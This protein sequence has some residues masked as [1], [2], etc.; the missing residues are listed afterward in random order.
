MPEGVQGRSLLP[1]LTGR[2]YPKSEFESI[3]AE[4]GFGGLPRTDAGEDSFTWNQAFIKASD[5]SEGAKDANR[6]P[7]TFDELNSITQSGHVKMVRK[8]DWKLIYNFLGKTELYNLERDPAELN[9]LGEDEA[10]RSEREELE[11]ELI[12]WLVRLQ[13]QLPF[14]R[15][16]MSRAPGNYLKVPKHNQGEP[17]CERGRV[18]S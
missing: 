4:Y 15:Y 13:D 2:Y 10:L 18:S 8:G 9:D 17:Q 12:H 3:Y 16:E 1:I 7:I 14:G 11:R 5:E 6:I